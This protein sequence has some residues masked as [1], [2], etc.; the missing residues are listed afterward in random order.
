MYTTPTI[1]LPLCGVYDPTP[2]IYERSTASSILLWENSPH[3]IMHRDH[4][5]PNFVLVWFRST[6]ES[7]L[8]PQNNETEQP[9]TTIEAGAHLF[10]CCATEKN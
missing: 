5:P 9:K 6:F 2:T 8:Q 3:R 4:S 1:L 10:K 7:H